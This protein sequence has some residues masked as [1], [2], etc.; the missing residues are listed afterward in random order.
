MGVTERARRLQQ[1]RDHQAELDERRSK[2]QK[3][4]LS[5][6]E[7]SKHSGYRL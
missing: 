2:V 5:K 3:E 4:K 1:W 7:V 6:L